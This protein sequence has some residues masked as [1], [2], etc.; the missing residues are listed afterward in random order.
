MFLTIG[1][2]FH[3]RFRNIHLKKYMQ[4]IADMYYCYTNAIEMQFL[5]W[6]QKLSV[7]QKKIF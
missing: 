5:A 4:T 2:F 6:L 1:L 3:G 7:S